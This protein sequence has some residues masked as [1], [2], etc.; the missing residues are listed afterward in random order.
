M[1]DPKIAMPLDKRAWVT[2]LL[3]QQIVIV[4]SVDADGTPG[5]A[6][7]SWVSMAAFEG[8]I[9]GFGC[10]VTH[11]TYHNVRATGDFVIN[12]PPARLA[13]IIWG[14]AERHGTDRI[15]AGGLTLVPAVRVS[16]PWIEECVGHIEC[17]RIDIKY[18]GNEVFIFGKI[19][20]V[21]ASSA[22]LTG[23]ASERYAHLD[24]IFFLEEKT[25]GSLDA[26]RQVGSIPPL[27]RN[28]F[29]VKLGPFAVAEDLLER[30]AHY[31]ATLRAEGRLVMAGPFLDGDD[32]LI[33]LKAA[34]SEEA[35]GLIARDP[36]VTAGC[37]FS[38]RP[39]QRT[40]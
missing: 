26:A 37:P 16:A 3:P 11:H 33:V 34:T 10:N 7:K 5:I 30:H 22:C 29:L 32:G 13:E 24:P 31:L 14:M 21:A 38:L 8:P 39:W 2:S 19:E 12:V 27:R 25:Y 15:A 36:L 40:F 23:A 17:R 35:Q 20:H 9:L 1:I 28:M 6:P 4:S 18:M